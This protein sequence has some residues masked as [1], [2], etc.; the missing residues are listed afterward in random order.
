M[1]RWAVRLT[2]AYALLLQAVLGAAAGTAHAFSINDGIAGV[3][4]APS[5]QGDAGTGD[6]AHDLLCCTLGCA[7]AQPAPGHD[8]TAGITLPSPPDAG[9]ALMSNAPADAQAGR[10]VFS[11][12]ARG[13]P[14]RA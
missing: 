6:A 2:L 4:C 9:T 8:G 3:L 12:E 1:T 5:G 13:P 11:F 7:A 10:T 14:A